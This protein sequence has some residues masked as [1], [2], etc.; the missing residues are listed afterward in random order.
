MK[1]LLFIS[2]LFLIVSCGKYEKPF[3]SFKSPEK[4]L[5]EGTWG[6]TKAIDSSGTEFEVED[7]ITFSID[8]NDSV[9]TRITNRYELKPLISNIQMITTDTLTGNWTW[10]Y[11][12]D[13]NFNKQI[14]TTTFDASGRRH[15]RV[16]ILSNKE[17]V[18]QD[19][20]F[21]NTTYHYKKL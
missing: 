5:T 2:S 1:V 4:R 18:Y 14:I 9:M 12:L 7:R 16:M 21:D 13:D 6:C 3:I 8:G 19:Q 20:T 11:A 10:A 15:N 17:F